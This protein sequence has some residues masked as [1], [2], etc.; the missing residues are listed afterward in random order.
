MKFP[1][2]MF[3]ECPE[4]MRILLLM[5]ILGAV[6]RENAKRP[7]ELAELVGI[8]VTRLNGLLKKLADSGY[9]TCFRDDL[10]RLRYFLTKL[11]IIKVCSAFS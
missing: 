4:E 7:A 6:D 9:V 11:G 5:Q 1:F 10:R 2:L 3:E 8:G